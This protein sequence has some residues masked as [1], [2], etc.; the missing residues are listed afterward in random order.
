MRGQEE[1][2]GGGIQ[3]CTLRVLTEEEREGDGGRRAYRDVDD[4]NGGRISF[5][6]QTQ[7]TTSE[8]IFGGHFLK[9]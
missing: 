6:K 4:P 2:G 5:L 3:G 1:G 9:I 8:G 7:G